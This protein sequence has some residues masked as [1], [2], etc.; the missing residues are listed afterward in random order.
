MHTECETATQEVLFINSVLAALCLA[1]NMT[2]YIKMATVQ[3]KAMSVIR[4][5][6]TKSVIKTRSR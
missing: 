5:F 3:E 4:F 6:E 2:S 1:E